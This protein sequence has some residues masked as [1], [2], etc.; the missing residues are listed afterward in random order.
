MAFDCTRMRF[1]GMALRPANRFGTAM[2]CGNAALYLPPHT[3][4]IV[5]RKPAKLLVAR[6]RSSGS[7]YRC[8]RRYKWR[9]REPPCSPPMPLF[10]HPPYLRFSARSNCVLRSSRM[11]PKSVSAGFGGAAYGERGSGSS[12]P[13]SCL[14][15]RSLRIGMKFLGNRL[16]RTASTYMASG[17]RNMVAGQ[18]QSE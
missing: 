9:K 1:S 2:S 12:V 8:A 3:G 11:R 16:P 13:A 10:P 15:I 7:S 18:A 4:S 14:A 6:P 5:F 17:A